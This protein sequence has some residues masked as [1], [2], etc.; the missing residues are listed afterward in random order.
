MVVEAPP[1]PKKKP[2]KTTRVLPG[3]FVLVKRLIRGKARRPDKNDRFWPIDIGKEL[4]LGPQSK[5]LPIEF[6]R[7]FGPFAT[8]SV[9]PRIGW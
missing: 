3:V 9:D 1:Q 2:A 7:G 6:K 4:F 5:W 8:N